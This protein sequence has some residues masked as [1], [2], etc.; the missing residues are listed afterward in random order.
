MCVGVFSSK[1][2]FF[3]ANAGDP[4]ATLRVQVLYNGGVGGLLGSVGKL[5]GVSDVGNVRS[6]AAWQPSSSVGMLGGTLP[7]LTRSV[8]FRFTTTDRGGRFQIDDVYLDPLMH[9]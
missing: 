2:R 4:N 3:V 7:L 8:Q 6:G 5:L 9:R 1:M